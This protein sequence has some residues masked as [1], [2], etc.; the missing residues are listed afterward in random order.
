MMTENE[1]KIFNMILKDLTII[2][3]NS[4]LYEESK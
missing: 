1:N 4:I 2:M 3:Y